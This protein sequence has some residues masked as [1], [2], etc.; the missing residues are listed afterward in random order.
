MA[1]RRTRSAQ[2]T[3]PYTKDVTIV[4]YDYPITRTLSAQATTPE[5][6]EDVTIV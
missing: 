4:Q 3:T 2:A 5:T 1:I 6:A